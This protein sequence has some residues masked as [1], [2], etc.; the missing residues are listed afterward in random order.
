MACVFIVGNSRFWTEGVETH[1][2]GGILA[3][4][5]IPLAIEF[6]LRAACFGLPERGLRRD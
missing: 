1:P 3:I 6:T 2:K 4:A 5:L